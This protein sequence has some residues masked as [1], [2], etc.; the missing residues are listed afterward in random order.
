V[1]IGRFGIGPGNDF[2]S[3]FRLLSR[4]CCSSF[5]GCFGVSF[6]RGHDGIIFGHNLDSFGF[7]SLGKVNSTSPNFATV[8]SKHR[9]N[10]YLVRIGPIATRHRSPRNKVLV[11]RGEPADI[12][13][14]K[15]PENRELLHDYLRCPLTTERKIM[16]R[17]IKQL[18]GDKLRASDGEIG[19]IKD[20]YFDDQSWVVRYLVADT[21]EWLPGRMVLI[22]PHVLTNFDL[23]GVC[24]TVNL[25]RKQIEASPS[26]SS[27]MPVSRQF[28]EEY[29]R[30]YGWPDYWTGGGLW[31]GAAFPLLQLTE[32]G[33]PNEPAA[34][35]VPTSEKGDPHL[36]STQ[37][38]TGYHIETGEGTIGHAIDFIVDEKSW[39][40]CHL[41]VETGHWYSGKEI[42]ISPSQI[43]RIS[44]AESK[45]FVSISKEAILKAPE[46]HAP[47][48]A[49]E[50]SLNSTT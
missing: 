2:M 50:D 28:E 45:V 4:A 16:L 43:Q 17:S 48:W 41:V 47:P 37:A 36:R 20:F 5:D 10:Q 49:Y 3:S 32:Q 25:T 6:V 19:H 38:I 31:G 8:R 12:A 44:Y 30:Y 23:D 29:Y 13:S 26:I 33:R 40:I 42:V 14:F 11:G 39:A 9:I 22:S 34:E 24:R 15:H 21:G 18:Y 7:V 27:H 46:Y 1:L 35:L